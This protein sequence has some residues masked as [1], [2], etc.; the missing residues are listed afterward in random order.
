VSDGQTERLI[1][2]GCYSTWFT[3]CSGHG[4][5]INGSCVCD[6]GWNGEGIW[7]S[8]GSKDCSIYTPAIHYINYI[9]LGIVAL[10][11]IPNIIVLTYSLKMGMFA[12][13]KSTDRNAVF[14]FIFC[15]L[16]V[17]L[18]SCLANDYYVH[19]NIGIWLTYAL[20]GLFAI[21]SIDCLVH[22]SIQITYKLTQAQPTMQKLTIMVSSGLIIISAALSLG[23]NFTKDGDIQITL[24]RSMNALFIFVS[25]FY[26]ISIF[27]FGREI[28]L[29]LK[30]NR[31]MNEN[32]I[33][34][35]RKV[36]YMYSLFYIFD[37]LFSVV[38]V[39]VPAIMNWVFPSFL[40][41]IYGCVST[42]INVNLFLNKL[43]ERKRDEELQNTR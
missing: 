31:E 16:G 29:S 14:I 24:I 12:F 23:T 41:A 19:N 42:Y 10:L 8:L 15:I 1:T 32:L 4:S 26:A 17:I 7:Y 30:Q 21:L 5:C 18:S 27:Y 33:G 2:L 13:D 36:R 11:A 6:I 38:I 20:L 37:A 43:T 3:A 25:M 34:S 28:E 22:M 35:L 9:G 40:V 39:V